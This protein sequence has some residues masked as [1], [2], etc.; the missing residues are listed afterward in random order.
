MAFV[1][2]VEEIVSTVQEPL[3]TAPAVILLD[4]LPFSGMEIALQ[5]A[6]P[7]LS[8]M[9]TS[10]CHVPPIVLLAP[11]LPPIVPAVMSPAAHRFKKET[12]AWQ[13]VPREDMKMVSCARLALPTVPLAMSQ[14][15]TVPVVSNPLLFLSWMEVLA[16]MLAKT[17]TLL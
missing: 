5:R 16:S 9:G 7:E 8:E 6:L 2:T 13:N 10:V 4:Q 1:P 3:P 11:F 15:Q 17:G 12:T 14:R